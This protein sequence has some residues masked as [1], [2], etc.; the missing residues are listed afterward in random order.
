[1]G[2]DESEFIALSGVQHFAFCKRQWSLIYVDGLW[3]ENLLTT[4]GALLHERAHDEAVRERRGDLLTVRGLW[5]TSRRLGLSGICDVVEFHADPRGHPLANEDG[6]WAA[7]PVEYK[8]GKSKSIDADR[9]QLCAQAMCLE[10]MLCAD[11]PVG[12]LYYGTTHSR[13]Q[14]SLSQELRASVEQCVEE[15]HRARDSGWS[16]PPK[17]RRAG[18][19]SCS[20]KDIC[21]PKPCRAPSVASYLASHVDDA[22]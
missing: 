20:I 2:Y 6:L 13:E 16:Y 10:E 9:F 11:I 1:M 14:V 18:C 19:Q 4:L 3:E 15:M 5:V 12:Y 17:K 22:P 21:L 7:T 8:R